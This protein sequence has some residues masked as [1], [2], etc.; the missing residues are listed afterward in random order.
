MANKFVV[1]AAMVAGGGVAAYTWHTQQL[2]DNEKREAERADEERL[3]KLEAELAARG[4][5][6]LRRMRGRMNTA[7]LGSKLAKQLIARVHAWALCRRAHARA[8]GFS[9][10][11]VRARDGVARA[12]EVALAVALASDDGRAMCGRETTIEATLADIF[13]G[14]TSDRALGLPVSSI[15]SADVLAIC[16]FLEARARESVFENGAGATIDL[17]PANG[18]G[19][20][21]SLSALNDHPEKYALRLFAVPALTLGMIKPLSALAA[22]LGL[23]VGI[24]SEHTEERVGQVARQP[25]TATVRVTM[26]TTLH[27]RLEPTVLALATFPLSKIEVTCR[28]GEGGQMVFDFATARPLAA[29]P[30][31]LPR[32]AAAHASRASELLAWLEHAAQ[33]RAIARRFDALVARVQGRRGHVPL[34]HL[35]ACASNLRVLQRDWLGA[36]RAEDAKQL[37]T[38]DATGGAALHAALLKT[39]PPPAD[40]AKGAALVRREV[41]AFVDSYVKLVRIRLHV[42]PSLADGSAPADVL[43]DSSASEEALGSIGLVTGAAPTRLRMRLLLRES[44][45]KRQS[46]APRFASLPPPFVAGCLAVLALLWLLFSW[47]SFMAT[48]SRRMVRCHVGAA[49]QALLD[50]LPDA[51]RGEHNLARLGW[52]LYLFLGALTLRSV[53]A[54]FA[55][56]LERQ[57]EDVFA[58]LQ[59]RA[60]ASLAGAQRWE[61]PIE[62]TLR[63]LEAHCSALA[64]V[65]TGRLAERAFHDALRRERIGEGAAAG[66]LQDLLAAQR[67]RGTARRSVHHAW[68]YTH[69]GRKLRAW[70]TRFFARYAA[71]SSV[72]SAR[73][74]RAEEVAEEADEAEAEAEADGG[75]LLPGGLDA[76]ERFL[77][78]PCA[79]GGKE[80]EEEEEEEEESAMTHSQ[81]LLAGAFASAGVPNAEGPRPLGGAALLTGPQATPRPSGRAPRPRPHAGARTVEEALK[82]G[83]WEL[84]R[85]RT[86]VVFKRRIGGRTQTHVQ[87]ATPSARNASRAMLSNLRKADEAA[88]AHAA[89]GDDGGG[90]G[91][92]GGAPGGAQPGSKASKRKARAGRT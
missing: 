26:P 31:A 43:E 73:H 80:E 22:L 66:L 25:T 47:L 35:A 38:L 85:K 44:A 20:V 21:L 39:V 16:A 61:P 28:G 23:R 33:C 76:A 57:P 36:L 11:L 5:D 75:A 51:L 12:S 2:A 68:R 55:F 49:G 56:Y 91:C 34:E 13:D 69:V 90:A 77:R 84:V 86:H 41:V 37:L 67:A 54:G 15:S 71:L 4:V 42:V 45:W 78:L 27:K 50:A 64:A 58:E 59:L 70:R 83:G 14:G 81:R 74:A 6:A 79:A 8:H 10:P 24:W 9:L 72:A 18:W 88:S 82:A 53:R 7:E 46:S 17:L 65:W 89:A 30:P 87:S 40:D 62:R 32:E 29:R 19:A 1:G 52:A 92:A 3:C 48:P 60:Y 63:L